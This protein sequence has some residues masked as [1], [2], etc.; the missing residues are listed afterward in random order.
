MGEYTNDIYMQLSRAN[1]MTSFAIGA[2][3]RGVMLLYQFIKRLEKE[4]IL[5]GG[6]VAGIEAFLKATEGKYDI[7]NI[8]YT[9][10]EAMPD[11][12]ISEEAL[13]AI[14]TRLDELGIRYCVLPDTNAD[15]LRI[16][17][18]IYRDDAQKFSAFYTQYL[19]KHLSGGEKEYADLLNFTDG[20]ASIISFPD[21]A[22]KEF[23]E[24]LDTLHV[25]YAH[26]PDLNLKDGEFQLS[27][28]NHNTDTVLR[29]YKLYQEGL[30]SRGMPMKDARVLTEEG[31]QE[32]AI[33]SN[34]DYID[35]A[36]EEIKEVADSYEGKID[37]KK[38]RIL[39]EAD[40]RISAPD[41]FSFKKHLESP[42]YTSIS[43]DCDTLVDKG[44]AR[45]LMER[46]PQLFFCRIPGTY[47]EEEK[48]LAVARPHVFLIEDGAK[49]RFI[50]FVRRN[51]KP[52]VYSPKGMDKAGEFTRMVD[53]LERFD[54]NTFSESVAKS[55]RYLPDVP[56]PAPVK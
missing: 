37:E 26:L 15:D 9:Q 40:N 4:E 25:D 19:R 22:E 1:H 44:S 41:Y 38:E 42:E 46:Y 55:A 20:N 18:A 54:E 33:L 2:G 45:D 7:M 6:E 11:G 13:S 16:Q 47:G 56:F 3:I 29:A 50:A 27:V 32:T 48:L 49:P 23:K 10:A 14:K 43:I 52:V 34:E 8:P 39:A 21:A 35:H 30:L 24:A 17:F 51:D 12:F 5:R 28:A 53:L 31:Y 36:D